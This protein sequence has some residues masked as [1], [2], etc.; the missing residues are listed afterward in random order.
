MFLPTSPT[1]YSR[2]PSRA[3]L[4]VGTTGPCNSPLRGRPRAPVFVA[5]YPP[6]RTSDA[7]LRMRLGIA[8]DVNLD[9]L[10]TD[11]CES[12]HAV[13]LPVE[14][15]DDAGG[16]V[17]QGWKEHRRRICA[18]A[19]LPSDSRCT[20]DDRGSSRAAGPKSA[21]KTTSGWST[22]TS[23][24]KS[25]LCCGE[26]GVDNRALANQVGIW[27]FSTPYPT[28]CPAC[29]LPGGGRGSIHHGSDFLE[30]QFE[31]VVENERQA[32]SGSQRVQHDEERNVGPS[33]PGAPR[34][35]D[36]VRPLGG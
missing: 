20:A 10:V 17:D 14:R 34:L 2:S 31:H 28:P 9:D 32:L 21:R 11:D 33:R 16:T 7:L 25:P 15:D 26:E 24:S 1:G 4:T 29:E 23:A 30:W 18:E 12:H 6:R 19:R 22:A 3:V 36:R 13:R 35:P 8:D 5:C 27:D